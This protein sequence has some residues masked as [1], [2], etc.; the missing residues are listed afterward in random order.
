MSCS[1]VVFRT[2]E[3]D[4]TDNSLQK[5]RLKISKIKNSWFLW[6]KQANINDLSSASESVHHYKFTNFQL[7][8]PALEFTTCSVYLKNHHE[9]QKKKIEIFNIQTK[10]LLLVAGNLTQDDDSLNL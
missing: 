3:I 4:A 1:R 6:I 5:A 10:E 9:V 7:V 8:T 2:K